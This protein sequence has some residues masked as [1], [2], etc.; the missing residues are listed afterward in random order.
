V[1]KKSEQ[2]GRER[3]QN[4]DKELLFFKTKKKCDSKGICVVGFEVD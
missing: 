4:V 2:N 3:E 1:R